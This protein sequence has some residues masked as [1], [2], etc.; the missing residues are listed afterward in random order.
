VIHDERVVT[1]VGV[2][3]GEDDLL[4]AL[5]HVSTTLSLIGGLAWAHGET[6]ELAWVLGRKITRLE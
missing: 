6:S 3:S 1:V 2:D 4:V 5:K